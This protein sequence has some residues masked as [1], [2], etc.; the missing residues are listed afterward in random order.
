MMVAGW[1]AEGLATP[2]IIVGQEEA[3]LQASMALPIV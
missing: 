1:L 2:K 3:L